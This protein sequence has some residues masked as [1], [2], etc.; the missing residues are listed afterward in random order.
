MI[1]SKRDQKIGK[2]ILKRNEFIKTIHSYF[3]YNITNSET[4]NFS[5][6]KACPSIKSLT[7]NIHTTV[8]HSTGF[9]ITLML[10]G[11][12]EVFRPIIRKARS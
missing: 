2:Y 12:N 9:N 11:K 4:L 3:G 1:S 10:E 5:L 6:E 7:V 8:S